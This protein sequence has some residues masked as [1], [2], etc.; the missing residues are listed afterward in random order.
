MT[1]EQ[2]LEVANNIIKAIASCGRRFLSMNSDR[3][4]EPDPDARVSRFVFIN[5]RLHYLDKYTE[6]LIF[7]H[8]EFR[9]RGGWGHQFSDGGTLLCLMQHMRDFIVKGE[10]ININYFGPWPKW[11]CGG[12][13]WGYGAAMPLLR[14]KVEDILQNANHS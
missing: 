1:R 6:A 8:Y 13:L 2:R 5:K 3:T 7:V 12:D 9:T 11:V 4:G 14:A 10:P